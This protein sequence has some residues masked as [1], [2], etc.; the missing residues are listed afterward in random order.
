MEIVLWIGGLYLVIGFFKASAHINSG[1]V[2]TKG[3]IATFLS[4]MLLW[5]IA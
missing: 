5:P 1:K 4:V 2:G 3:P